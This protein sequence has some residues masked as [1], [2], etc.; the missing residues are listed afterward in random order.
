[1]AGMPGFRAALR[2]FAGAQGGN[3]ALMF[4]ISL[5]ML[6]GTAAFMV[7]EAA[8]YYQRRA[9]QAAVDLAA[10]HAAGNPSQALERARLALADSRQVAHGLTLAELESQHATKLQVEAG[11]YVHSPALPVAQRFTPATQPADAVRIS[12][13]RQGQLF[14]FRG[15]FPPPAIAVRATAN[16][17]ARAAFSIGSSL[18]SVDGGMANALLNALLGINASAGVMSY[19]SLLNADVALF[20]VLD[21][22]AGRLNLTAG[23]YDQLLAGEFALA[24]LVAA[25]ATAASGESALAVQAI[26]AATAAHL[27]LRGNRLIDLGPLGAMTVGTAEAGLAGSVGLLELIGA[28]ASIANG[29]NQAQL[30]MALAVPGL[31]SASLSVAIGEP[32]QGSGWLGVGRE[33]TRLHTAQTRLR[34]TVTVAGSGL[35]AGASIRLPIYLE[36]AGAEA[37]LTTLACP[38]PACLRL[39]DDCGATG[40]RPSGHRGNQRHCVHQLCRRAFSRAGATDVAAGCGADHRQCG[41]RDRPGTTCAAGVFGCRR[42]CWHGAH[43]FDHHASPVADGE[44]FVRS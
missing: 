35:L 32:A 6:V 20:G 31:T 13:A 41:C 39:G 18:A 27:R 26:A 9:M 37:S 2:H 23:T 34:L 7:D 14:F 10:I 5:P 21:A 8:L 29:R 24:D 25:S 40:S 1:M 19:S 43:G 44:P 4:A 15:L 22:L 3:F 42:G 11:R 38:R 12:L 28:G 16:A 17:S 33:Q 36:L 30:T